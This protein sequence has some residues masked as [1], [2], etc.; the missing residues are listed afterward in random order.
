L[1][2]NQ[3][4][5]SPVFNVFAHHGDTGTTTLVSGANGSP[6]VGSNANS[7]AS[8]SFATALA[9]NHNGRFIGFVS[10]ATHLVPGQSGAAGNV[11]LYDAQAPG[12]TLVS[13]VNGSP[14]DGAGGN[15]ALEP[16][17]NSVLATDPVTNLGT[18]VLLSL[19]DDGSLFAFVSQA[20]N[21]VPGET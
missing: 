17:G 6:A 13:G 18:P 12:L 8:N 5:P 10:Q 4:G 19:S 1:V 11:F 15:V 2:P 3:T 9:V 7:G 16:G 21:L 14:T 20:N